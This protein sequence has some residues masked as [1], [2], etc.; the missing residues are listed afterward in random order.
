MAMLCFIRWFYGLLV[1]VANTFQW[2]DTY[3]IFLLHSCV[4]NIAMFLHHFFQSV[5]ENAAKNSAGDFCCVDQ[6]LQDRDIHKN[7]LLS[8]RSIPLPTPSLK[9]LKQNWYH[10]EVVF[11][12]W[13]RYNAIN[14]APWN[15]NIFLT[16]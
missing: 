8:R 11:N 2:F 14:F 4:Q 6:T 9:A 1:Y 16:K 13:Y 10:Y 5:E 7:G 3:V 12:F 15:R